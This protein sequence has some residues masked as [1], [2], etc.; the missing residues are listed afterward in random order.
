MVRYLSIHPTKTFS[1]HQPHLINLIPSKATAIDYHP[2]EQDFENMSASEYMDLDWRQC[3]SRKVRIER[4]D[5]IWHELAASEKVGIQPSSPRGRCELVQEGEDF[6][7][8]RRSAKVIRK[9]AARAKGWPHLWSVYK[10]VTTNLAEDT[11]V[12]SRFMQYQEAG[13]S[14][15]AQARTAMHELAMTIGVHE[16]T[17]GVVPQATGEIYLPAGRRVS[18]YKVTD[19]LRYHATGTPDL[20]FLDRFTLDQK[21]TSPIEPLV[22]RLQFRGKAPAAVMVVEHR[23]IK[24]GMTTLGSKWDDIVLVMVRDGYYPKRIPT[25]DSHKTAGYPSQATREFLHMLSKDKKLANVPFLYFGDHDFQGFHI[26]KVLKTGSAQQAESSKIM[27]CP[28]L[29]WAGPS[30]KE[31]LASPS[32]CAPGKRAQYEKDNEKKTKGEVDAYMA[33]WRRETR[34]KLEKKLQPANKTDATL[35]KGFRDCG[36]LDSEPA[37]K[38]ELEEMLEQPSKF[39]LANLTDFNGQYLRIFMDNKVAELAVETVRQP[40]KE[41]PVVKTSTQD[42]KW[43]KASSQAM[44]S[45]SQMPAADSAVSSDLKMSEEE[46][47]ALLEFDMGN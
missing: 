7:M 35:M 32:E 5:L 40:E 18:G 27:V 13:L 38:A 24:P 10:R 46:C 20:K 11:Q 44:S 28:R 29:Q 14:T 37:I 1:S 36:W 41:M 17:L 47:Q 9:A 23:N 2:S 4:L 22:E 21:C 15:A 31:L 45:P 25:A 34:A 39:R 3:C 42:Q 12:M 26:Y 33:K 30:K 43:L 8:R 6:I 16:W 19:I